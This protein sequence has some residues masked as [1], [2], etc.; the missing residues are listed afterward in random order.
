MLRN[1]KDKKVTFDGLVWLANTQ[2]Q[3]KV[4]R[5]VAVNEL[6][7]LTLKYTVNIKITTFGS[8]LQKS[9]HVQKNLRLV[10]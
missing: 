2:L 6:L 7:K 10:M 3:I 9:K 8:L 5:E 1:T 4:E